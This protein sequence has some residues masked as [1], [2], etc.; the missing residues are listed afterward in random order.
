MRRFLAA[1]FFA[2]A[3]LAETNAALAAPSVAQILDAYKTA[4]GGTAWN[5][6]AALETDY[7][8]IGYGL[9]GT[10]HELID[11]SDGRNIGTYTLGPTAG[12]R[13]FDGVHPW[14]KD[15]SGAISLQQGGDAQEMAINQAYRDA[16]AWW[17]PDR[18]GAKIAA[19]ENTENGRLHYVLTVEPKGGKPFDAWFDAETRYLTKT[20]EHQGAETVVTVYAAYRP[21][22]GVMLAGQIV[23]VNGSEAYRRTLTLVNARFAAPP[24]DGAFAPPPSDPGEI[25]IKD[26]AAAVTLPIQLIN[27]HI[28]GKVMLDGKGPFLFIF[29]TGGHDI[30]TP[31]LAKQLGLNII[32]TLPGSG[33]GEGIVDAGFAHVRRVAIGDASIENQTFVAMSL[34]TLTDIEG[35]PLPGMIGYETFSRF[36]VRIDYVAKTLSLIDPDRF[37]STDA[38]IEIPFVFNGHVPEVAGTFEGIPAKFDIDTGSRNELTLTKPFAEANGLRAKHPKGVE[39][40]DGWGIGGPTFGYVTRADEMTIGPVRI[41]E[42]VTSFATQGKGAFARDDYQGNVGGGILK[43]FIVT[44]DYRRQKMYLKAQPA[45]VADTGTYDRAGLWFNAARRGY[46]IVDVVKGSP[47]EDAGL[48]MGNVI[49]AVDGQSIDEIPLYDLRQRLRCAA[50]G[51]QVKLK[52]KDGYKTKFVRL[53][54]RDQF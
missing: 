39:A 21:I 47:A 15:M 17:R 38:G 1:V 12:A 8:I 51:T 22:D 28:Y 29:D 36:V 23:T 27:N 20:I 4:T 40:M 19:T 48:R 3:G 52:I 14:Q 25:R 54:L 2:L 44:L 5:G 49:V 24:D 53:T 26:K 35:A 6:K 42:V 10:V 32:G 33:V 13:G 41:E 31:P 34:E 46:V 7:D 11:L 50:P 16:N 43:R 18:G 45:P 37:V 9:T 30:V